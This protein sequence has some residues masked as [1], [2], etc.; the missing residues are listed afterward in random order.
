MARLKSLAPLTI[1]GIDV[2]KPGEYIDKRALTN[3]ANMEVNRSVIRKRLGTSS[4]GSSLGERVMG[5]TELLRNS[6]R[7]VVRFGLTKVELL[8]VSA[9]TWSDITGSALTGTSDNR[10]ATATPILSGYRTLVFSNG[11]D[12]IRKYTGTGN[13]TDLGGSP[14]LC[15]YMVEFGPYLVLVNVTDGG[16]D[17][18]M[19]VQWCDTN[20]IED[21]SAGNAGSQELAEDGEDITG[22]AL[23]KNYIA[24][25]KDSSIYL[26]YLVTTSEVFRFE[27][28]NTGVGA[29]CHFTIQNL[30]NGYQIFLARDGIH[31][32]D[33][34]SA[35][36][37]AQNVADELREQ[38]N[39]AH[40]DK[41]WS[42]LMPELNEYWVG[43]PMG[44]DTEASTVYKYNFVTGNCYKDTRSGICCAWKYMQTTQKTW[45]DMT[46]GWDA[47]TTNWDDIN[48]S[49]LFGVPIFGGTS[50]ITTKRDNVYNDNGSA[51]TAYMDTK[52]FTLD[53]DG[54]LGRW[55]KLQ[56]WAKGSSVKVYYSTDRG[57]T[58][59]LA[60]TLTLDSAYPADSSP[61]MVYFDFV[62]SVA[63]FRFLNAESGESFT[64]KKYQVEVKP[65][66]LIK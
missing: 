62:S 24:V 55:L 20:D 14:P 43:V 60:G 41:C 42:V 65:R 54:R 44:S 35:P 36:L 56:L 31:I 66:E 32:F 47:A 11:I 12:N 51:V 10:F 59:T 52:D 22:I 45:D 17:Y 29:V 4:L 3:I 23:Y 16:T 39:P 5:G 48:F 37:A 53:E 21:W 34:I 30:P 13:T 19:R 25:H 49:A 46:G 6:L 61:L 50:G 26:G 7:Y 33:G 1:L 8:N 40:T 18:P 2:S 28:Q 58:W 63:R 9:E 64:L 15:K 27:R 38:M 57:S